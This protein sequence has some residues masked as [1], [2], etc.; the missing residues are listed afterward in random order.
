[1]KQFIVSALVEG[2]RIE[3]SFTAVSIHHAIKLMQAKYTT[4]RNIYVTE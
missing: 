1:M 2:Y 4:A 3:E